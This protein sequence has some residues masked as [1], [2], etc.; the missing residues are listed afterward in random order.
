MAM[1][2]TPTP[3]A[4][5]P[6]K[7]FW[8][9][10]VIFLV[11]AVVGIVMIVVSFTT[12]ANAISDFAE[13]DVPQTAEVRLSTGEYWV[14]VGTD[15][16]ST[17]AASLV[18]VT[19]TAPD[20]SS[21]VLTSD[22]GQYDAETGGLSFTSLGRI[23][24]DQAGVYTF[25]TDGPDGTSVRVGQ[26]P[27]GTFVGLLI[28]GIA[29]GALGFLVALILVIVTLVRRSK[30]KK[31][32]VRTAGYPGAAT[33]Y[34]PSY[35]P[36]PPPAP[37]PPPTMA[38]P[39]QSAPPPGPQ[40]PPAPATPPPAPAPTPPPPA[41][42][43]TP[44]PPGP[45]APPAPATPPPAPAPAPTPPPPGPTPPPPGPQAPPMAPPAAPPASDPPG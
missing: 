40:A 20:G 42:A 26:L 10:L 11:T 35:A 29:L 39:G 38:P 13:I 32:M 21:L 23:D 44:P 14:F 31:Q 27:I 16:A 9:A 37:M 33:A 8:I 43:P 30:A 45:Q 41:P 28:G 36:T 24:I 34:P 22:I 17:G 3:P 25:E 19:V 5:L 2:A 1:P 6:S 7:G 15:S 12:I 18:D 4:K